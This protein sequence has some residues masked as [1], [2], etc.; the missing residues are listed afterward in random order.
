MTAATENTRF[1]RFQGWAQ[2]WAE[3]LNKKTAEFADWTVENS[4]IT[5][6]VA[7][8]NLINS[9][10]ATGTLNK[11]KK[12]ASAFFTGL[13]LSIPAVIGFTAQRIKAGLNKVWTSVPNKPVGTIHTD[14]KTAPQGTK[15][16]GQVGSAP[17]EPET[18]EE[19][20]YT[21]PTQPVGTIHNDSETA[22]QGTK[23]SEQVGSSAQDQI[24]QGSND[25]EGQ[26]GIFD[27]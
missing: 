15:H 1:S 22:P 11:I 26:F 27:E 5:R 18:E 23:H 24:Q 3:N 6:I 10:S 4:G 21:A 16:S 8:E 12:T 2:V 9:S 25:P 13:I 20:N 7:K 14:S 17:A 19:T